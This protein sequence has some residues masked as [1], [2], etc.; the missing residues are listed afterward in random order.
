V[1]RKSVHPS[2]AAAAGAARAVEVK[3]G[4]ESGAMDSFYCPDSQGWHIGH[5]SIRARIERRWSV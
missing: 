5:R 1:H 2:A 3:E 4:L